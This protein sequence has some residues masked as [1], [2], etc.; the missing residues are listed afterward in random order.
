[1]S[2]A[3]P[4]RRLLAPARRFLLAE[5]VLL[6]DAV[7]DGGIALLE[8]ASE[9]AARERVR[10]PALDRPPDALNRTSSSTDA[11][12][13]VTSY[14]YDSSS[15]L[16]QRTDARNLVTKYFP[17]DLNRLGRIEH[18]N[19]ATLVDSVDYTYNAVGFRTQMVDPTGTTTYSPDPLDRISSV[20]FPGPKTVSYTYDDLYAKPPSPNL[21]QHLRDPL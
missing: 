4:C 3:G 9:D 17:D 18:W 19:G 7:H 6:V 15:N 11:L 13:R 5:D 12:G 2:L 10:H 21:T 14:Q 20:T 16:T 1:M 8:L